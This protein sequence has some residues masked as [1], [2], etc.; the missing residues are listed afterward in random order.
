M[1]GNRDFYDKYN[2]NYKSCIVTETTM[3]TLIKD[4]SGIKDQGGK[5]FEI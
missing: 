2:T 1:C 4:H 5:M 3:N